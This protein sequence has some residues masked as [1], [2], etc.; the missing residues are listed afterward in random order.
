MKIVAI[1]IAVDASDIGRRIIR[2]HETLSAVSAGTVLLY[3]KW[4]PGVHAPQGPIEKIA[5]IR[6]TAKGSPVSWTRD[7][8]DVYAFRV[9]VT[10]GINT[11][12]IDFEYL[13]A[14][15]SAVGT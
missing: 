6:I 7:P 8:V 1:A 13:S 9:H 3:P 10:P 4:L 5:G 12:D 11:I 15:S 2:I 14:T